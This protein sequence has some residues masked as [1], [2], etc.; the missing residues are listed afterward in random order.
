MYSSTLKLRRAAVGEGGPSDTPVPPRDGSAGRDSCGPPAYLIG[1]KAW[2][3]ASK[4]TLQDIE[5][6]V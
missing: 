6:A 2:R 4:N 3:L 1:G 5:R